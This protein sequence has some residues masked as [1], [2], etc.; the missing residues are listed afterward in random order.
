MINNFECQEC[1]SSEIGESDG[2]FVCKGCGLTVEDPVIQYNIGIFKTDKKGN[3]IQTHSLLLNSTTIGNNSERKFKKSHINFTRLNKINR[4][5]SFD[6]KNEARV[7]FNTLIAQSGMP[8]NMNLF[9]NIFIEVFPKIKKHS[10]SRNIRLFCTT[11]Y[12]VV[13]LRQLKYVSLKSLLSEQNI[14]RREFY[15][16]MKA[17]SIEITDIFKKR[18]ETYGMMVGQHI[19]KV[20][21]ELCLSTEVRRIAFRILERY[22]SKLGYKSRIKA[23]S[24]V[25]VAIRVVSLG[26]GNKISIWQISDCLEVTAST[27]YSYLKG[28]NIDGLRKKYQDY[29]YNLENPVHSYIPKETIQEKIRNLNAE[30]IE[31]E[32]SKPIKNIKPK[33]VIPVIKVEKKSDKSDKLN[34][35]KKL[36]PRRTSQF[37]TKNKDMFSRFIPNTMQL[38]SFG[39][40]IKEQEI[41]TIP[42]SI[43]ISSDLVS[44]S[45]FEFSPPVS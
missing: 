33:V 7:I 27:V 4:S 15:I 10:K 11:I 23:A 35:I 19:S 26:L 28:F 30:V 12:Y 42:R 41:I 44:F 32:E 3:S 13:M 37:I 6:E 34:K 38:G 39:I 18:A 31:M 20:C 29:L 5:L 2:F 24:A 21:D 9:M 1:G 25:S 16:C 36:T 45:E 22:P 17:I 14:D 43:G 8:V 40:P